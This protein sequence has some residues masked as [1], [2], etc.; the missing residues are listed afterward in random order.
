MY[1][2]FNI[3]YITM[4]ILTDQS[5]WE[6]RPLTTASLPVLTGS[7]RT[8]PRRSHPFSNLVVP[9]STGALPSG[10]FPV[11]RIPLDN[12]AGPPNVGEP[13]NVFRPAELALL[14]LCD[15]VFHP[16]PFP[17]LLV[18][19]VSSLVRAPAWLVPWPAVP[20]VSRC[21][22]LFVVLPTFRMEYSIL[23]QSWYQ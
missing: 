7:C 18:P 6:S 17:N 8:C 10:R 13:C 22:S 11:S 14:I 15:H 5:V 16:G 20:I 3:H 21:S 4:I 12:C 2:R 9:T 23:S 1:V 19:N